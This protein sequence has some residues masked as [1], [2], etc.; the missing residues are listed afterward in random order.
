MFAVV[1]SHP[2]LDSLTTGGKGCALLWPF[3]LT[4]Y[5]APWRLI[6]VAPIGLAFFSSR[7]LAVAFVELLLFLPCFIYALW[8][9][10]RPGELDV[11][12]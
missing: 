7:G 2:L 10:R 3:D 1:A 6:P 5:F 12:A 11:A 4:R 8:P 9:Q